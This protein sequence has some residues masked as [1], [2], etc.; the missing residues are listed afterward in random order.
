MIN[1]YYI[2]SNSNTIYFNNIEDYAKFI[3]SNISSK[4]G[5]SLSKYFDLNE[6]KSLLSIELKTTYYTPPLEE[7]FA[8]FQYISLNKVKVV[9]IGDETYKKSCNISNIAFGTR[10]STLPLSLKL[11]YLFL[12]IITFY[13]NLFFLL[14]GS[15]TISLYTSI[16]EIKIKSSVVEVPHPIE[17]FNKFK[18]SKYFCKA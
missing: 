6:L 11:L 15:K 16:N 4:I 18:K 13:R 8:I 14:F 17:E 2:D 3:G 9:M 7:L 1:P 10:I 5:I 12:F